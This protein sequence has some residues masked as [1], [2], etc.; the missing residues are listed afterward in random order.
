M[1]TLLWMAGGL[2]LGLAA[3]LILTAPEP[4]YATGSTD[5]ERAARKAAGWGAKQRVSGTGTGVLGKVKEGF[6]NVTGNDQ[7]A[8][9]GIGDQVAGAVKKTAGEVAQAAG[10]ALHDL[11]L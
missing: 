7:L 3:F 5:V 10:Q 2:G 6:G 8:G 4:E 9:E 1:K 11:N